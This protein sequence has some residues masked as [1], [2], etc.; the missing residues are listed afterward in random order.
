MNKINDLNFKERLKQ[1]KAFVFDVDG[2]L[3]TS[4]VTILPDGE[5]GRTTNVK[6]GFALAQAVKNGYILGLIS[7]GKSEAVAQRYLNLGVHSVYIRSNDKMKDFNDFLNKHNISASQVLYMGDDLPDIEVMKACAVAC[8]PADAVEDVKAIS[9][10]VSG[11]N[12]GD[13]CVRDVIAQVMKTQN[14]WYKL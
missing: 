11:L 6:D 4:Q 13:G 3:S 12:G 14:T 1:I 5:L 8:C 2:V 9:L 7:G 10:Y